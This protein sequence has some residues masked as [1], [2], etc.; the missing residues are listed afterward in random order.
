MYTL[1]L[2]VLTVGS[3]LAANSRMP[4]AATE[5]PVWLFLTVF[6]IIANALL[7]LLRESASEGTE[8]LY[9]DDGSNEV[10]S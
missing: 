4:N 7:D 3:L 6:G 10:E 1:V 2:L 5:I 9:V 8:Q